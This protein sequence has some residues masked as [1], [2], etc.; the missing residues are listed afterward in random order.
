MPEKKYRKHLYENRSHPEDEYFVDQRDSFVG[1]YGS[2]IPFLGAEYIVELTLDSLAPGL[3][4][5]VGFLLFWAFYY[6]YYQPSF[7]EEKLKSPTD[8]SI[9]SL[10]SLGIGLV[11]WFVKVTLVEITDFLLFKWARKPK[12]PPRVLRSYPKEPI[13]QVSS[14]SQSPRIARRV[15]PGDVVAALKL[16]GLSESASWDQ[17]HQQ[18]RQLAKKY[19]PDLHPETTR[20]GERFMAYDAAY[21]KLRAVKGSF[22][23]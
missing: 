22:F 12:A 9:V 13:P 2:L 14:S 20:A 16:L 18:Y 17:I 15:L 21:R 23:S 3:I 1:V 5:P 19:H 7:L 6:T 11:I 4:F 10:V 8:I